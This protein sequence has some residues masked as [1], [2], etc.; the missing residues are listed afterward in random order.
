MVKDTTHVTE[1]TS[2]A[3]DLSSQQDV[4]TATQNCI[5]YIHSWMKHDKPLLKDEKME[6]LIIGTWQHVSTAISSI[7][8]GT[9]I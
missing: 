4:I 8:V 7:I 1:H 9:L 6:F 3:I 2:F 5:D